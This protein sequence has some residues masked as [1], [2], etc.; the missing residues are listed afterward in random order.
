MGPLRDDGVQ[1]SKGPDRMCQLLARLGMQ[2][3]RVAAEGFVR[4]ERWW[5][6]ARGHSWGASKRGEP[7]RLRCA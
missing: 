3:L 6:G 2:R 1:G 7:L 4:F 5:P